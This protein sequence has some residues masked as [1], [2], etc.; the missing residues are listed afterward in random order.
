[1][2]SVKVSGDSSLLDL[3]RPFFIPG[4]R[5]R[6]FYYWDSYW[7]LEGLLVSKMY[8]SAENIVRNFIHIINTY[9]YIPNGTRKYYLNRSQPPMFP[10][11][12]LKILDVND[13]MLNDLVFNEGLKAAV[14]EYEFFE[15]YK[16]VKLK[17]KDGNSHLLNY[18]HVKTDFPRPESLKEDIQT[19]LEQHS[20]TENQI[21]GNLKSAAESGWDFSSRW[22]K[23]QNDI[24]TV[25][26]SSQITVDLNAII[27]R[28]EEILEKLFERKKDIKNQKKYNEKKNAR[29][30]A[31][32]NVLWNV[33]DNSWNDYNMK[34]GEFIKGFYFS[35]IM[36]MIYGIKP[37]T[38]E[39][40]LL[41]KYKTFLFKYK[42]GIP[43]S[44]FESGQQWDFPNVW[45]P[46]QHMLI[47][48]LINIEE[49]KLAFHVSKA[50][51]NSVSAGFTD[52]G[53]FFEKY[54]CKELGKTGAGGEYK[55]QTGFG[56]TNGTT[57]AIISKYK[58][59]LLKEYDFE[60]EYEK[61]EKYLNEK[62]DNT[63]TVKEFDIIDSFP[64][65]RE[66]V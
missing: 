8:K 53:S 43:A 52:S 25:Q 35:N 65:V 48:Y 33:K 55:P 2:K 4:G 22:F 11:M 42:G 19:Y 36:P 46:H 12:L 56:W 45:A 6:E 20:L 30:T 34:T 57:L 40:D 27:Y 10:M 16:S 47:E 13:G 62:S 24:G 38:S 50:F 26:A 61:I 49:D 3:E 60:K 66:K 14:K 28:N 41:S 15:K 9:G 54:N 64:V 32:N 39:Y 18:Y 1:M 17:G 44:E 58:N 21:Y 59:R 63:K 5:F 51:F 23:K 31:I 37:I 29:K 7:I